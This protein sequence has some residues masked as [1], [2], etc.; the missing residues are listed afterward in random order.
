MLIGNHSIS[1]VSTYKYLGIHFD[2]NG[3]IVNDMLDII[4]S[5]I[6]NLINITSLISYFLSHHDKIQ[7]YKA[8]ILPHFYM[9]LPLFFF[10]QFRTQNWL[11]P[12]LIKLNSINRKISNWIFNCNSRFYN[13]LYSMS[14]LLN[15]RDMMTYSSLKLKF[16]L[17]NL[18]KTH[19]LVSNLI[20]KNLFNSTMLTYKILNYKISTIPKAI[21]NLSPKS[22]KFF[23]LS[24]KHT[25]L[26]YNSSC[27][28][29]KFRY[30]N[31]MDTLI[32]SSTKKFIYTLINWRRSRLFYKYKLKLNGKYFS[33]LN[34]NRFI[35]PRLNHIVHDKL[36]HSYSRE[37]HHSSRD[38]TVIDHLINIKEYKLA[39]SLIIHIRKYLTLK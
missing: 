25:S 11:A 31:L 7:L 16:N 4:D 10:V 19:L 20:P 6:D 27:H 9:Y 17:T 8:Y 39:Y 37:S 12:Y 26:S 38:Y 24:Y 36:R 23:L 29:I 34:F 32:K 21:C 14:G 13:I 22:F 33:R 1:L 30:R 35:Y 5:K 2:I 15:I 28:L 18:H 3:I